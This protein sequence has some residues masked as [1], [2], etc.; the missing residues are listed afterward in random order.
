MHRGDGL[1]HRNPWRSRSSNPGCDRRRRALRSVRILPATR[2]RCRAPVGPR[3]RGIRLRRCRTRTRRS[4]GRSPCARSARRGR[5]SIGRFTVGRGG[6][7]LGAACSNRVVGRHGLWRRGRLGLRRDAAGRPRSG[8]R[9]ARGHRGFRLGCRRRRVLGRARRRV[10]TTRR[11]QRERVDVALRLRG[12]A[13]TEMDV[14]T[15]PFR[16]A[17]GSSPCHG[18]ALTD[19][20]ALPHPQLTQVRERDGVPGGRENGNR[21]ALRGDGAGEAHRPGRR[22]EDLLS[23]V[24]ADVDAAML[25]GR[26]RI[27]AER[28]GPEH[29]PAC[30]PGPRLS[31]SRRQ[32]RGGGDGDHDHGRASHV[33]F[34]ISISV[35]RMDNSG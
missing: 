30:R 31:A 20:V 5:R 23:R 8:L 29:L 13:H 33:V 12:H 25:A 35:A 24:G 4:S 34:L 21:L 32:Q 16:H 7:R 1:R 6:R 19:S 15:I 3:R 2:P 17:A 10:A 18:Q 9:R 11:Q 14:G 28:E 27:G 26:V 22:R